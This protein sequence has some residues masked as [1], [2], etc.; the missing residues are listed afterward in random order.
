MSYAKTLPPVLPSL[1]KRTRLFDVLDQYRDR[2]A[3]WIQGQAGAGKTTLIASYIEQ[4]GVKPL[5]YRLDAGDDDPATFFHYFSLAAEDLLSVHHRP[6]PKLTPESLSNLTPFARL[7]F[8]ELFAGLP[9]PLLLVFDNFQTLASDSPLNEIIAVALSEIPR[10][11]N[12]ILISRCPPPAS[13]SRMQFNRTLALL[14]QSALRLT[15]DE[16][17]GLSRLWLRGEIQAETIQRMNELVDG[18]VAG[19][20]L[21]LER[22]GYDDSAT[23]IAKEY[24]FNYFAREIFNSLDAGRRRFLLQTA[25][26]NGITSAVARELTGMPEAQAILEDLCERHY[27][28][29]RSDQ[30]EPVYQ[31]HPLFRDFLLSRGREDLGDEGCQRITARAAHILAGVGQT[32]EAI[33]LAKAAADWPLLC[34]L[35]NRQAPVMLAQQRFQLLEQ[36]L[37]QLP[38]E[39]LNS[40]PWLRYWF[41]CCRCPFD[42]RESGSHFALAYAG[43]KA[44]QDLDGMLLSASGAILAIMTEWDDFRS[45]DPWIATLEETVSE[46]PAYPSASAEAMVVLAMLGALLFRMPQH[47]AMGRWEAHAGRL[48]RENEIDISLRIDIGN[49][50]VHWQYWKGDLAAATHTTDILAQLVDAGGSATLPRLLSVMNHAIHDWHTADFDQSLASID[51]GLALAAQMGVHIMDD[52]LMAQSVYASL[53]REDLPTARRFL[54]RMKP[55]LQNGRR[56]AMSQYHYLSSQYHLIAGDLEM[57][58]HH[59]QMAVDINRQVGVPFPEALACFTLAQIHFE[60]GELESAINLLARASLLARDIQSRTL[61][62][63]YDLISAWFKL[64]QRQAEAALFHLR[65]GLTLQ[66]KMGFLNIPGWRGSLMKPLLLK[67]LENDIE[68]EFVQRLIRKRG[69]RTDA[70]PEASQRW[71]WPVKIYTLGRFSLLIDG[72]PL[73]SSGKAQQKPLELLKVLIALGGREIAKDRLM[74]S[75]W[76]DTDGDNAL[77]ALDITL[78]R[79][80]KLVGYEQVIQVRDRKLSLNAQLCWVDIWAVERLLGQTEA[81]LG[82]ASPDCKQAAKLE[83]QLISFYKGGFLN[84]DDEPDCIVGYRERLRNRYLNRLGLLGSY[85]EKHTDWHQAATLYQRI[86]EMDDRQEPIYRRLIACYRNRGHLAEAVATYERCREALFTHYGIP[87]SAETEALYQSLR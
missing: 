78:H 36:W 20:V 43:F 39:A 56:L 35:I 13:L 59:G 38:P 66:R 3:I 37:K 12:A 54:D 33:A 65:R 51:G 25:C 49:V 48:I 80:R 11:M 50:L 47:P 71:P 53:S 57:A 79:F 69:L 2:Q 74:D 16:V 72:Q 60:M 42:Q 34:K 58:R 75:L 84:D 41:G 76:P 9:K 83:Q 68:P 44:Q 63:L 24:F 30:T 32:E 61:A 27:F 82:Q 8:R 64:Q 18:W 70:P 10:G 21:L 23:G 7:F 67:A 52:R 15:D 29:S 1:F 81:L 5:W 73:Q 85:W 45:L 86:L 14:D 77:R 4:C 40:S 17:L 22:G 26:L 6:Q 19:L 87:P 31:Y 55:S 62:L 28:T 46:T